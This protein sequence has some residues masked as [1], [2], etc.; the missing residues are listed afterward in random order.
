MTYRL[1][2]GWKEIMRANGKY[3]TSIMEKGNTVEIIDQR[4]LP[5]KL[6]YEPLLTSGQVCDAISDMHLR[7]APLIGVA[8][9]YGVYL[10]CMESANLD[11]P[12]NYIRSQ[13]EKLIATRPTAA[14]LRYAV[15]RVLDSIKDC[16]DRSGFAPAAL[17]EARKI[18][19]EELAISAK[20]G[21]Y[22]AKLLVEMA[23]D[24]KGAPVN[25]LTHCNAGWLA[26]IDLGTATAP[27]YL[28]RDLGVNLHVWIDE[29]RPR[30]QGSRLTAWEMLNENIPHTIIPDNTGGLLMQN[31]MIDI[32]I[33]G[34]D[35]AAKNGDFANK[36]G[37]YL[38]ALAAF[39]NNIPFY[40]ALPSSSIDWSMEEGVGC[41]EIELRHE[42]E[43]KY[44]DG[45]DEH[46]NYARIL[47]APAESPALNYAFDITPARLVTGFITERGICSATRA[48]L[49]K[50]FPEK[51]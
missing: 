5:H 32:V 49:M 14:N 38:K 33:V 47:I 48:G 37:T 25:I 44:I 9:A 16:I 39:D 24:K 17:A 18:A 2:S 20:I 8:A 51:F 45:I 31:K 3:A 21:D 36:T 43:I 10:A 30:N 41:I 15:E 29:T 23:A 1:W 11:V 22:G 12:A 46:G 26:T 13:A 19:G 6:I 35:R 34:A 40:V 50:L 28:A 4:W 27:I 42:E 7:G